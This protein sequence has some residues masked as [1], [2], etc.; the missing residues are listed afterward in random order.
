MC[1]CIYGYNQSLPKEISNATTPAPS[2]DECTASRSNYPN[3]KRD[4]SVNMFSRTRWNGLRRHKGCVG[5]IMV[6]GASN[7]ARSAAA[8]AGKAFCWF[9]ISTRQSNG[10]GSPRLVRL[11]ASTAASNPSISK[12]LDMLALFQEGVMLL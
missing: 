9:V 5:G 2:H 10:T 6:A 3:K 7:F 8:S 1:V 12:F 11:F 4:Y